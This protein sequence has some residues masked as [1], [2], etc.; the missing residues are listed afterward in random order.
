MNPLPEREMI[1]RALTFYAKELTRQA[2]GRQ[3][4]GP[5]FTQVRASLR[6]RAHEFGR[7]AVK[8]AAVLHKCA[9]CG[10]M[11]GD[12]EGGGASVNDAGGQPVA[13][14]HPLHPG[15]AGRPDCYSLVTVYHQPLGDLKEK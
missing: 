12:Y 2:R 10:R 1:S 4:T 14:C 6:A 8:Y 11:C 15:I 5:A 9:H 3:Y 7:L 13:V